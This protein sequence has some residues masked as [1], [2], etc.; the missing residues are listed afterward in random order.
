MALVDMKQPKH[1][2]MAEEPS[3]VQENP[4]PYGLC[5]HLEGADMD[6][7]GIKRLPEVGDEYVVKAI[8]KVTSVSSNESEQNA[9]S[10]VSLQI[11]MMDAKPESEGSAEN[12]S[13]AEDKAEGAE[14]QAVTRMPKTV[15]HSTYRG[16]G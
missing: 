11:T 9:N 14:T 10:S 1:R 2:M 15:M 3:S 8:A 5:L 4:Y 6:K 13:Y 16:R 7:L 12:D